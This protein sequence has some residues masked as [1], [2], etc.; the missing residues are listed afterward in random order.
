V[1]CDDYLEV[2]PAGVSIL[3]LYI[4]EILLRALQLASDAACDEKLPYKYK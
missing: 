2:M 4:L 1:A 3:L